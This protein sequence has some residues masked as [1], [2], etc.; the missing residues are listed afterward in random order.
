MFIFFACPMKTNQKKGHFYDVFLLRKT[1][2][3]ILNFLQGFENFLR[4]LFVILRKRVAKQSF[5][6]NMFR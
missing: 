3:K 6:K 2:N 1:T 5:A 4:I